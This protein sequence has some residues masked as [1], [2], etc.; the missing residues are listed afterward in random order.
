MA[1]VPQRYLPAHLSSSDSK[2]IRKEL[3]KS[4]RAYAKGRYH[5]RDKV[6]S[7]KNRGSRWVDK[8]RRTYR[9]SKTKP[10]SLD[11]LEKKTGCRKK[12]LSKI[13]A[14]GKGAYF[15]SGSRPNQTPTS[16]G[17]ARLYSSVSGGPAARVD[18]KILT[19][20]CKPSSKALS[21]AKKSLSRKTTK[22]NRLVKL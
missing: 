15:S 6:K 20:H 22:G 13:V 21:L 14:K 2:K 12:G 3:K 9:I 7:F 11:L 10:L 16:W 17:L 18:M 1:R 4:R 8:V 19:E 5:V